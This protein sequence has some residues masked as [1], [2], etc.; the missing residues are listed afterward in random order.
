[1]VRIS[2]PLDD[3]TEF[4]SAAAVP[5]FSLP[6]ITSTA[7]KHHERVKMDPRPDFVLVFSLED[8]YSPVRAFGEISESKLK[9]DRAKQVQEEYEKLVA[10][11]QACDLEATGRK[12]AE[13]TDTLLILV[14]GKEKRILE[15]V[16][17]ER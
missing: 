2:P 10:R 11:L 16:T 5:N 8:N 3:D 17:R 7:P 4:R 1:M 9:A 12:G 14:R 13:G 6:P 15:E